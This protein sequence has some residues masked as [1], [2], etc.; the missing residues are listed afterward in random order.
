VTTRIGVI[1]DTHD[2][3]RPEAMAALSGSD[4]IIHGGDVCEPGVLAEL[5]SIAPV[6]AV[7]GNNDRRSWARS[8]PIT[9]TLD[10]EGRRILVI[11]DRKE[12]GLDP[13]AKGFDVVVSGHSHRPGIQRKDGVLYLNPGSAGRRR[14]SLPVSVALLNVTPRSLR[15][16]IVELRIE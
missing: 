12:L 4:L 16:R 8:L 15:A 13:K 9:R 3:V 2:L 14:F 6:L 10:V 11:H 7:R 1:S 5:A